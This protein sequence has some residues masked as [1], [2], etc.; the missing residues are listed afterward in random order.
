MYN[1]EYSPIHEDD[2]SCRFFFLSVRKKIYD[3]HKDIKCYKRSATNEE[4][5][6]RQSSCKLVPARS[7]MVVFL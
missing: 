3:S 4:N 7:I 2:K 1:N 5:W 6:V